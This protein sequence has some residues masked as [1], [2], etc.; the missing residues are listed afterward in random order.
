MATGGRELSEDEVPAAAAAADAGAMWFPAHGDMAERWWAREREFEAR[1][2][3]R[4]REF[5][6]RWAAREREFDLRLHESS[7]FTAEMRS[8]LLGAHEALISSNGRLVETLKAAEAAAAA[9]AA[10]KVASAG[11]STSAPAGGAAADRIWS[12]DNSS[13]S[14][15]SN[16][17]VLP[18]TSAASSST[19]DP[20]SSNTARLLLGP[21]PPPRNGA[22]GGA[23]SEHSGHVAAPATGAA[24]AGDPGGDAKPCSIGSAAVWRAASVPVP[25]PPLPIPI[26]PPTYDNGGGRSLAGGAGGV[27]A[28]A[29]AVAASRRRS[30]TADVPAASGYKSTAAP[31]SGMDQVPP[32]PGGD[33]VESTGEVAPGTRGGREAIVSADSLRRVSSGPP[34]CLV[35]QRV[36]EGGSV[37]RGEVAPSPCTYE[38][39][40]RR[41]LAGGGGGGSASLPSIVAVS[42][43][44]RSQEA[45]GRFA[46]REACV[47][48][49]AR[50]ATQTSNFDES[51]KRDGG[52]VVAAAGSALLAVACDGGEVFGRDPEFTVSVSPSHN[53]K[54]E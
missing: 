45:H 32:S 43:V 31:A 9:A 12:C 51:S 50:E 37:A 4:E 17:Q 28:P 8:M 54:P 42:T 40:G 20:R 53:I 49:P 34:S 6:A 5:D 25:P 41:I 11:S 39:P 26:P 21:A 18:A 30:F 13:R 24:G 19:A 48:S 22:D 35:S 16:A 44:E 7:K 2:C 46:R 52:V 29:V 10:A 27:S 14:S 1:W 15:T 36:D 38:G 47:V 3:A 23:V 33:V